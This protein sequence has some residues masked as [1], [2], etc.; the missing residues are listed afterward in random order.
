MRIKVISPDIVTYGAMVIG[1]VLREQGHDVSISHFIENTTAEI[2]L[3]SLYSTQHLFDDRIKKVIESHKKRGGRC[4][5]GGP[6]SSHPAMVL[7]ELSPDAVVIG[8]GEVTTPRLVRDGPSPEMQGIAYMEEGRMVTTGP[9][10]PAPMERPL[11]LIPSDIG[12]QNIRG[13][14]V[15]IE[16]H[17]GCIGGCGF[18]QVPRYFGQEIRSRSI[19]AILIEVQAFRDAG[20]NR[21]SISG[22]TGSLYASEQGK[23]NVPAFVDLLSGIAG[24]MGR[25][26]LS[27]PDIRVDCITDEVLDA[28]RDYT[29]GWVFFGIESGSE[30][31]LRK[32][33][34]GADV[35]QVRD[36]VRRCRDHGLKVAGS[37]IVGYPGESQDDYQKT[38]DLIEELSLDD[39]F[40]SAAEPIPKTPLADLVLSTPQHENPVYMPHTGEYKALGL[41][42]AEA[43]AFDLMLHADLN[44]PV[45]SMADDRTFDLYLAEV[46]KQGSDIRR[47]TE[48]LLRYGK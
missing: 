16:T 25:K 26:N 4:Y 17:R 34:K 15:Y 44:K 3:L 31:I 6:V 10:S 36:A 20:A 22:G 42:V 21:V 43:R 41:S 46:R 32:M 1:G 23:M 30:A 29:I 11:P 2:L 27:S 9:S 8:E 35:D 14:N 38:K 19:E 28:I 40:V 48:C 12:K 47:A 18:C 39:V 45:L 24:I 5:V 7:G 37:F 13:A 33:R